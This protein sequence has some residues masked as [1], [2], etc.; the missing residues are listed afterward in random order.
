MFRSMQRSS[1]RL[2]MGLASCGLLACEPGPGSTP[3]TEE[4]DASST[5]ADQ[6]GSSP[7]RNATICEPASHDDRSERIC[8]PDRWCALVDTEPEAR[9]H[10]S[11]SVPDLNARRCVLAY[12][13]ELGIEATEFTFAELVSFDTTMEAAMPLLALNSVR[14]IDIGC[15]DTEDGLRCE[16]Y[17]PTVSD[18]ACTSDV[19]CSPYDAAR[20]DVERSCS[21]RVKVGCG[22]EARGCDELVTYGMSPDG[23][24]Y[25]FNNGCQPRGF[26]ER[27]GE[28]APCKSTLSRYPTCAR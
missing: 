5:I 18:E 21:E 8:S 16:D 20:I 24:C 3:A 7:D 23:Q 1:H 25:V 9:A 12:A 10:F 13:A 27:H 2:L 6:D 17:C 22:P 15:P 26:T 4:H 14:Y 11:L 28:D 19:R